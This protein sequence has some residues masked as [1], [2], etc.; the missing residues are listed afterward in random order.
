M[1]V[2]NYLV[3]DKGLGLDAKAL[4][5]QDTCKYSSKLEE[6]VNS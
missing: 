1:A 6:V 2:L 5:D 3:L 4:D